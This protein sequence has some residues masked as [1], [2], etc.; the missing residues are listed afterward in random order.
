MVSWELKRPKGGVVYKGVTRFSCQLLGL[1]LVSMRIS[2]TPCCSNQHNERARTA[3]R[4]SCTVLYIGRLLDPSFERHTS[5]GRRGR[6][7]EERGLFPREEIA[8]GFLETREVN[9]DPML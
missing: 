9:I 5:E 1:A 2:Y 6:I 3:L 4:P 8:H 7:G